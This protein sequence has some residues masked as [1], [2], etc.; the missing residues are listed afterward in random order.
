[1]TALQPR[2]E[3]SAGETLLDVRDLTK[4]FGGG[5]LLPGRTRSV[6]RAVDGVS[7]EIRRGETFG[8]VGETGSGKST[9]GRLVLRLLDPTEGRIVF[10]G[11]DITAMPGGR[12]RALRRDMQMVFQDPYGSLDPRMKVGRIIVEPMRV[13]GLARENR[14]ARTADIM[15]QVGL[16]PHAADRYPHEFSGG[17]RQRIGI[18]RAMALDPKLLVLDEPVS[19][20]DVSIQAQILN[21]LRDIQRRTGVAFL[22]IAHDLA[23]VRHISD[24]IAVMYLGRIVELATRENLYA[25]PRHP[26]S[27][28]LLSAAPI[29]NLEKERSRRRISL[30]GEIGSATDMPTGC[31]FHPRCFKARIVARRGGLETAAARD[32]TVLPAPCVRADPA[33]KQDGEG[34]MVAC[35]FPLDKTE[36]EAA[37]AVA[38]DETGGRS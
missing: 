24:R 17:Q 22:F 29:P 7:F 6:V 26:Y 2:A 5:S 38:G 3:A 4:H 9:L 32:G 13:H 8:V 25:R 23:V 10:D 31:R 34:Q 1:M 15:R 21:L 11:Q 36:A 33:L 20:L 19:A 14:A 37:P 35:H 18:A 27:A 12:V 16:A 30:Y 28:A